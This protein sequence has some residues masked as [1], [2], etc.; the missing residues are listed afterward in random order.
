VRQSANN[1]TFALEVHLVDLG[2]HARCADQLPA[3]V[4]NS[5]ETPEHIYEGYIGAG[6]LN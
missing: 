3:S 5:L 6:I 1:Q 4:S 2:T